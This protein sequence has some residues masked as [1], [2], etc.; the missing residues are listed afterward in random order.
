MSYMLVL[1]GIRIFNLFKY[2]ESLSL[3]SLNLQQ[4]LGALQLGGPADKRKAPLRL[5][6]PHCD[7]M[8]SCPSVKGAIPVAVM[9]PPAAPVAPK[10]VSSP[11]RAIEGG[12][13]GDLR[14]VQE[15]SVDDYLVGGVTMFDVQ[16]GLS[17][18]GK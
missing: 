9:P 12:G 17:P 2:V 18:A 14:T 4:T 5:V 13:S 11:P 15:L 16:T 6:N 7:A 1:F 8:V 10:S 3:I